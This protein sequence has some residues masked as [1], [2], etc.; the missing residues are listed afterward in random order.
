MK[1]DCINLILPMP[2][3][4]NEAYAGYKVRHKSKKYK[5]WVD[6]AK[7]ELQKQTQ[8]TIK[9]NEWLQVYY[10]YHTPLFYKNWKKKIIDVFNY[11]KILSDFLADNIEW[12]QDHLIKKGVV[13]KIDSDKNIVIIQIQEII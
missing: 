5:N 11:E 8:Y 6:L 4:V 12:F 2:I 1:E 3:S 7:I 13:S 9:W 10:E